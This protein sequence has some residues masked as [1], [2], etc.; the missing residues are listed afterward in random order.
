MK[1]ATVLLSAIMGL[2]SVGQAAVKYHLECNDTHAG[3]DNGYHVSI[4][5]DFK[6]AVVSETTIAG[7]H[8]V[9]K[10]VCQT[11]PP[12]ERNAD[13]IYKV[14]DCVSS[15]SAPSPFRL[16]LTGGGFVGLTQGKLLKLVRRAPQVYSYQPVAQVMCNYKDDGVQGGNVQ[17]ITPPYIDSRDN[18]LNVPT[19]GQR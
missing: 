3:I 14:G 2:A 18:D 12:P 9:A 6:T 17:T 11:S 7:T 4:S 10:L 13:E 1:K 5:Q 16:E 15:P 19:S 8:V